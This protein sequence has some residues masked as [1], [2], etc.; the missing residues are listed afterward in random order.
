MKIFNDVLFISVMYCSISYGYYDLI[1]PEDSI[2]VDSVLEKKN[3]PKTISDAKVSG[4][5]RRDP[6]V[7]DIK[8]NIAPFGLK[9][10]TE[11]KLGM[12]D[13]ATFPG[14]GILNCLTFDV[15]IKNNYFTSYFLRFSATYG[16][17][18]VS[19]VGEIDVF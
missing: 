15:P 1:E 10:G 11:Y 14:D 4:N 3:E 5:F 8:E 16:L 19:A 18:G 12:C 2:R 7:S 13:T 9:W 6:S 17:V